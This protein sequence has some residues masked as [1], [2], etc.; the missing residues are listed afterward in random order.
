MNIK[1][2]DLEISMSDD[3]SNNMKSSDD[4]VKVLDQL[5][6]FVE[7]KNTEKIASDENKIKLC[8]ELL[9]GAIG[10]IGA[11]GLGKLVN[12]M[13]ENSESGEKQ[14]NEK[15]LLNVVRATSYNYENFEQLFSNALISVKEME[16]GKISN[17]EVAGI[18]VT[19][20]NPE[21]KLF[22]VA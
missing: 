7:I 13:I 4:V 11:L 6:K 3:I 1:Y 17:F 12:S 2:G 16:E 18:K 20:Y 9:T 14:M 5:N 21:T 10:I 22:T 15:E 8:K 19:G